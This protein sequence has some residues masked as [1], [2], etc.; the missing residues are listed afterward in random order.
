MADTVRTALAFGSNVGEKAGNIRQAI[1]ALAAEDGLKLVRESPLYRTP[2]WG[3]TDQDWFCN[4]CALF[5]TDLSPRALLDVCQA[6]ER[7]LGRIRTV[8][9]G[10]RLIDIDIITFGSLAVSSDALTI[11]HPHAHERGFVLVPLND[12]APDLAL[13]SGL[14]RDNLARADTEGIVRLPSE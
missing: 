1:E 3:L 14:V 8:R 6:V 2:P 7:D 11:P 13:A 12:I 5:D 9:W 10:P 4:A